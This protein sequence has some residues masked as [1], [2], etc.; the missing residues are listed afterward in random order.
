[1]LSPLGSSGLVDFKV[2]TNQK[3][4]ILTDLYPPA[5]PHS[6]SSLEQLE[7]RLHHRKNELIVGDLN[8]HQLWFKSIEIDRGIEIAESI[9]EGAAKILTDGSSTSRE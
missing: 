8:A 5:R 9:Q 7:L 1:M 6:I 2:L 4:I 3:P